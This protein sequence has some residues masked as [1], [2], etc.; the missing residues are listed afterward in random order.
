MS[1][2]IAHRTK[3]NRGVLDLVREVRPPFSPESTVSDFAETLRSYRIHKVTGDRWGGE[4]VR[5]PFRSAGIVYELADKPKSDLYRDLLPLINSGRVELLDNP[6]LIGQL[7]NLERRT[8]RSGKDSIDHQ[9]GGHD[10]LINSAAGA[11]VAAAGSMSKAEM[12]ARIA[13]NGPALL[14]QIGGYYRLTGSSE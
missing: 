5:E 12:Y 3:D 13:R 14:A 9:P 7:C 6:R 10:D 1:L 11:L 2:A 8:A 4:F